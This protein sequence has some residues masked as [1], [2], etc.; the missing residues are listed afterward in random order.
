LAPWRLADCQ[1]GFDRARRP[2]QPGIVRE[3]FAERLHDRSE[4]LG[5]DPQGERTQVHAQRPA[6]TAIDRSK[7]A[8]CESHGWTTVDGG[9]RTVWL[10]VHG[11]SSERRGATVLIVKVIFKFNMRAGCACQ[12]RETAAPERA[13]RGPARARTD[14]AQRGS[15]ARAQM[16]R[17]AVPLA[18]TSRGSLARAARVTRFSF[19]AHVA[20]GV[21]L[22][23]LPF[24]PA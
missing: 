3:R 7:F 5:R 12:A 21:A 22:A 10:L 16:K 14:V 18:H 6:A 23:D 17:N 20:C 24:S 8:A 11:R 2:L 4:S 15:L 9:Y 19:L 1:R 13:R